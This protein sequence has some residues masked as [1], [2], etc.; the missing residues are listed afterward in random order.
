MLFRRYR[1][2]FADAMDHRIVRKAL[3]LDG[4]ESPLHPGVKPIVQEQVGEHRRDRAPLRRALDPRDQSGGLLFDRRRWPSFQSAPTPPHASKRW[5]VVRCLLGR[6][7]RPA[8][9]GPPASRSW[10]SPAAI[11]VALLAKLATFPGAADCRA[12]MTRR[13]TAAV[14]VG[15]R[16]SHRAEGGLIARAPSARRFPPVRLPLRATS[17]SLVETA[18]RGD[19]SSSSAAIGGDRGQ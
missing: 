3:E 14:L 16:V 4:P 5:S 13:N 9:A 17:C 6:P 2:R 19:L 15:V 8:G 18:A 12:S 10:R 1:E 11:K 7:R